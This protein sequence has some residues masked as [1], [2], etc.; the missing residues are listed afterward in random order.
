[1]EMFSFYEFNEES[2]GQDMIGHFSCQTKM[3]VIVD[4][5]S[6]TSLH[7]SVTKASEA[8]I[9]ARL[10]V[11]F[12]HRLFCKATLRH[13]KNWLLAGQIFPAC[14]FNTL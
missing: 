9:N 1:M 14:K 3:F 10:E 4:I 11:K 5:L 6:L 13:Q 12:I 2:Q 7:V 8:N